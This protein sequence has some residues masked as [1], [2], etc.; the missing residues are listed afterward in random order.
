MDGIE[1]DSHVELGRF[2]S[3]LISGDDMRP[4]NFT[5]GVMKNSLSFAGFQRPEQHL[6][7]YH[8]R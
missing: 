4:D 3:P 2:K 5:M 1:P 7:P 8:Q 6:H